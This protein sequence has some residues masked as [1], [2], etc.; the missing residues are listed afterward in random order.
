MRQEHL[1][2]ACS[3]KSIYAKAG[4]SI[5][6]IDVQGG[7]VAD[8][9]AERDGD[10][11]EFLS[12]AVTI[13]CNESLRLNVGD[14]IYSNLYR[15]MFKVVYDEVREHDLL[16]PCCRPEMYD[17]FYHNGKNHPNCFDN[18]NQPLGEHRPIIQPI[19]L[20]MFTKVDENGKVTITPSKSKA[21]NRIILIAMMKVRIAIAACSVSEGDCNNR[22]CSPIKVIVA[23]GYA[24]S[25]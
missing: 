13:D 25:D 18:I 21:G 24:N 9:F 3:G 8:F 20:F 6:V 11:W 1:I 19:N 2:D 15:P 17:F 5:T 23:D 22:R 12:T 16:F 4:Q 10:P 14:N 7:Q